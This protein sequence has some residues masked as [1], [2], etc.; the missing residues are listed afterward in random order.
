MDRRSCMRSAEI[1]G[2]KRRERRGGLV[3]NLWT[4]KIRARGCRLERARS[5]PFSDVMSGECRE[6]TCCFVSLQV[7][8]LPVTD[9][10]PRSRGDREAGT[11]R[12]VHKSADREAAPGLHLRSAGDANPHES[13]SGRGTRLARPC[14][15]RCS[16]LGMT[17]VVLVLLAWRAAAADP[18]WHRL[19]DE[20]AEVLSDVL[21][22]DTQ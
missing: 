11:K 19:G 4:A 3:E 18:D 2:W 16:A 5:H 7:L 14:L 15:T 12:G 9:H 10:D 13:A 6:T 22:I 1:T 17:V 21:R 8:A 20:T